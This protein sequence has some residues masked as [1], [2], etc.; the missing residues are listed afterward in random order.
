[1]TIPTNEPA[2]LRAGD[3]WQW[4]REDLT[5]YPASAWTLTYR[6]KNAAGG[7]E[8]VASADG[9]NF[10]VDEDPT[11]TA[12]FGAGDY[13]W[14]AQVSNADTGEKFTVE[15]GVLAVEPSFFATSPTTAYDNRTQARKILDAIDAYMAGRATSDQK[16]YEINVGGTMRRMVHSNYTQIVAARSYYAAIVANEE[17]AQRANEGLPDKRR[18]YVRF[19]RV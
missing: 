16:E 8:I 17:A 10:A 6:F 7:F 15:S 2:S 5:D 4:R 9:D 14:Q 19:C 3:T 18:S 11:T 1:M 13:D 12:A